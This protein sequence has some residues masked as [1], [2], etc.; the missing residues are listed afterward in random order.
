MKS[1]ILLS[2][3]LI[4]LNSCNKTPDDLAQKFTNVTETVDKPWCYYYWINDDISKEGITKDLLAMKEAGMGTVLIGNINPAGKDG[5]VPLFSDAWWECMVHAVNEGHRIG[6]DIGVFNSP[7]WSQSGGPWNT[8]DKTMRYIVSSETKVKGPGKVAVNLPKP[9]SLFRD[10]AVLAFPSVKT[11]ENPLRPKV[12]SSPALASANKLADGDFSTGIMFAAGEKTYHIELSFPEEIEAN[13]LFL[14]P[15]ETI[16]ATGRL[17]A[18]V[19]GKDSLVREFRFDRS[20][21]RNLVGPMMKGPLALSLPGVKSS[22]FTLVLDN[23]QSTGSFSDAP[24]T[25]LAEIVISEDA[26]LEKY[27]E[28]QLGKMHPT[29][30]PEWNSYSWG[31]QPFPVDA[32][33]MV[34]R[35]GIVNLSEKLHPD[36][37]LEWDAPEGDW[38]ILRFGMTPTGVKNHPAAPQ[39]T[40]YEVDKM[41]SEKLVSHFENFV[42]ELLK[43]VPDTSKEA[44]KYVVIDSYEVGSQNWTDGYAEKFRQKYGY[45][46]IPYLPALTGRIVGSVAESERFLW[47]LRRAVA[48]D[49]AEEYVG[50]LKEISNEHH[51]KLWL[52]NYGHWGFPSEFLKYGGQSDLVGGEFWNERSGYECKAASSS[53]HIYGK[54]TVYSEA[55][56]AS[57]QAFLRHPALLKQRG[58]WSFT[59]GINHLVLHVYIHQP[60]DNRKPGV[61]AWFGTEFNR[62]NTWFKYASCW[63]DYIRRCQLMLQQG[64]YAADVCYFIGEDAPIMNGPQIPPLPEG[65]SFD[66]INAET[67][68]TR[69]T[70]K[71]GRFTLPDGMSYSIMILPPL[72]TM[73]PEVIQKLEELVKEGGIIYGPRPERSPSLENYPECDREVRAW[74]EKLWGDANGKPV[75]LNY[76]KGKVFNG[77]ELEEVFSQTGLENDVDLSGD[78]PVLWTHRTAESRDIYFI[79]NQSEKEIA[80]TPSFRVKNKKPQLWNPLTGE[81][82]ALNE[83][84]TIGN[85]IRV[86]LKLSAYQSYFVVFA[87]QP[88]AGSIRE[89]YRSNFPER[90]VVASLDGPW[91]VAFEDT[92]TGPRN[93]V[94]FA[95][96]A[97]WPENPDER[98]RYYSGSAVYTKE[99]DMDEVE[100]GDALYLNLGDVQVVS[101]VKLNGEPIGGTWL[102]P[103]LL[104]TK[105]LLKKGKNTIEIE[106]AN[107]WRNRLIQEKSLPENGRKAWWLIDDIQPGEQLQPSGLLGPATVECLKD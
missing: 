103:H 22:V 5:N 15:L 17:Y 16:L 35:K 70:V 68:L 4:L 56:T 99:F 61:N 18:H 41:D 83:F 30:L 71:D 38:T 48:D 91:Q 3:L 53:A 11:G 90:E 43:R 14:Y 36:G 93:P 47:D 59:E 60:D 58:D 80:F 85:H 55:F 66:Y 25:G 78:Y 37:T 49:I 62:H 33:L 12:S 92:A 6:I 67:I 46:P 95:S 79:T 52:E 34:N 31:E 1:I 54:P 23:I 10:I 94:T 45:D 24:V 89:G 21:F 26:V 75:A 51:M 13:S 106:V 64:K 105:G 44:M 39:G 104:N 84:E 82:R 73:R 42:G 7:G 100:P 88:A 65:Y 27:V 74:A 86:P 96:L 19:A 9:D 102:K 32:G 77:L 20:N 57:Q 63:T 72:K 87:E 107:L 98:I 8:A 101:R 50:G 97:N 81:I 2:L 29:P 28:K 69:L 76:G 40:G